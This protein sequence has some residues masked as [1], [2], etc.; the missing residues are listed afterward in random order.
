MA[1]R[2]S[3]SEMFDNISVSYEYFVLNL[4]YIRFRVFLDR[5]VYANCTAKYLNVFEVLSNLHL[6]FF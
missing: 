1:F 3:D 4:I 6:S 2:S 5:D